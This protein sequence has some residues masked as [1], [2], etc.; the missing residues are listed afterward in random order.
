MDALIVIASIVW[1]CFTLAGGMMVITAKKLWSPRSM[2]LSERIDTPVIVGGLMFLC[3]ISA[4]ILFIAP[5]IF[6]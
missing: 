6:T 4:A 2:P 5:L 1:F 3:G